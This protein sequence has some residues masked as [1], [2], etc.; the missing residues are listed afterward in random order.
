MVIC[1]CSPSPPWRLFLEFISC[2]A[3]FSGSQEYR[4]PTSIT[5]PSFVAI[6]TS[7]HSTRS[8]YTGLLSVRYSPS[9]LLLT[10]D[11]TIVLFLDISHTTLN[12]YMGLLHLLILQT[13]NKIRTSVVY[14]YWIKETGKHR[15]H[16]HTLGFTKCNSKVVLHR[17]SVH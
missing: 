3:S 16:D 13:S 14:A 4:Y 9:L 17:L 15:S 12:R 6:S 2:L 1:G 7:G 5:C 10:L 11:N 8:F